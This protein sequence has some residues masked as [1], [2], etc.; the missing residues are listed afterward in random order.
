MTQ[1]PTVC[2]QVITPA[3]SPE[4]YC[5]NFM[6][7]CDVPS[8]WKRVNVCPTVTS[9]P[10]ATTATAT[11]V[12]TETVTATPTATATATITSTATEAPTATAIATATQ[13][14][15]PVPT[16]TSTIQTA[17]LHDLLPVALAQEESCSLKD[18][19]A[20][21]SRNWD[22]KSR[23]MNCGQVQDSCDR[24]KFMSECQ[25]SINQGAEQM[26]KD[27]DGKCQARYENEKLRIEMMCSEMEDRIDMCNEQSKLACDDLDEEY[28]SCIA[29]APKK[30]EKLKEAVRNIARDMC[31]FSQYKP[32]FVKENI[33][34]ISPSATIPVTI[35]V[36]NRLSDD[37]VSQLKKVI[38]SLGEPNP[39][40]KIVIYKAKMK[41]EN[42]ND[43]KQLG[44]VL[45]AQLDAIQR[46]VDMSATTPSLASGV[47]SDI[48]P[49]VPT[50]IATLEAVKQSVSEDFQPLVSDTE[51]KIADSADSVKKVQDDINSKGLLYK[52]KWFLG[53]GAESERADSEKLS[54]EAKNLSTTEASLKKI[55]EQISDL[56]TKAALLEQANDIGKRKDALDKMSADKKKNAAGLLSF[57][58][59][60]GG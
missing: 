22:E 57:L 43:L 60:V 49:D 37:Q 30:Q 26:L 4:G 36:N 29:L 21:C 7:P 44:F 53:M 40:G 13:A 10:A 39:I 25:K 54:A 23:Y 59:I 55:A 18:A 38:L 17:P 56:S 34:D 46:S 2:I 20:S 31:Q 48:M 9:T 47:K 41:A 24:E 6:T 5:K 51:G 28:E 35:A 16:P 52:L 42:F 45:D 8:D 12:Q 19:D 15:T 1:T 27:I 11:P 50:S 32:K 14:A 33:G 58:K 3:I